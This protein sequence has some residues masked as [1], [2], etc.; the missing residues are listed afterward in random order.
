MFVA[1]FADL[2]CTT[3]SSTLLLDNPGNTHPKILNPFCIHR[4]ISSKI[5]SFLPVFSLP[6]CLP[7]RQ[8]AGRFSVSVFVF[9]YS[10]F[11][12]LYSFL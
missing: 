9:L 5:S 1:V 6:A 8:A 2:S 7:D 3:D 10:V 12:I 11:C 4:I